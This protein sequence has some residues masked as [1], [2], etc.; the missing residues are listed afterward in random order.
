[1]P[2]PGSA[3]DRFELL[4]FLGAGTRKRV[5]AARDRER[6]GAMVAVAVFSTEGM[7]ATAQARARREAEAMAK[8]GDHPHTVAVLASGQD[9]SRPYVASQYMPGGDLGDLLTAA[10]GRRLSVERALKITADVAAGL[11]HAHSCGIIHRDIKPA[12]IWLDSEANARVGDFGLATEARAQDAVERTLVGTAAYLPPEQAIGKRADERSDLYSLGA[13][14]YEMLVGEP[15]FPGDDPVS[16]ISRH[17]SAEPVPPSRHNP[18]VPAG[19]RLLVGRLLSKSP[20]DRPSA[21]ASCSPSCARSTSTLPKPAADARAGQPPRRACRRA[22][23][24]GASAS[25]PRCGICS[26]RRSPVAAAWR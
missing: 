15:P 26:S 25:S 2:R 10:E 4:G 14:L 6:N 8:L 21:A 7:A 22:C 11:E 19:R 18:E 13:L 1:M 12:N 17:L 23:S 20:G 5:Y 16:I 3:A 24:S 9:G